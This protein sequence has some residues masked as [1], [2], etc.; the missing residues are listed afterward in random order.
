MNYKIKYYNL[1]NIEVELN[2]LI[3]DIKLLVEAFNLTFLKKIDPDLYD[4]NKY[5]LEALINGIKE[6]FISIMILDKKTNK[7]DIVPFVIM[8][9]GEHI[10]ILYNNKIIKDENIIKSILQDIDYDINSSKIKKIN[11]DE[12]VAFD[13]STNKASYIYNHLFLINKEFYKYEV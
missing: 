12:L 7:Y 11:D 10:F 5:L 4:E 8:K 3:S 2:G 9:D 13:Y 6:H 1:D